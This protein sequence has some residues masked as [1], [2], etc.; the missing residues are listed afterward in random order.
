MRVSRD[1]LGSLKLHIKT[2]L[3]IVLI[4]YKVQFE[5]EKFNDTL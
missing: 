2:S 4:Y 1:L 3:K 5:V